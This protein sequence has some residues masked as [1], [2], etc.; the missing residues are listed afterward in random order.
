M[1][2]CFVAYCNKQLKTVPVPVPHSLPKVLNCCD[3]RPRPHVLTGNL[4]DLQQ[5]Y[6]S[7][8]GFHALSWNLCD[9]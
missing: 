6:I 4:S 2:V 9:F 7:S 1:R 5:G 3:L 8:P